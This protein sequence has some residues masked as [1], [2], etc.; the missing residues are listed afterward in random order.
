MMGKHEA[1]YYRCP[2]CGFVAVADPVWL[3][4]AYK[5]PIAQIDIGS[6]WRACRYSAVVKSL[7]NFG[8][9]RRGGRFLDYGAGFGLFVRRMR[10]LG[11][12]FRGYDAHTDNI[13][14]VG[15]EGNVNGGERFELLTALEVFEH[16]QDPL[17]LIEQMAQISSTIIF[18]TELIAEPAPAVGE[19]WYYAPVTGQH[20]SFY[21][22]RSLQ[23]IAR[24]LGLN[25]YTCGKE[26][27]MLSSKVIPQALFALL[28]T[29]ALAKWLDLF[30]PRPTLLFQDFNQGMTNSRQP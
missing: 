6:L 25:F 8:G 30:W 22:R 20:I 12:D 26:I 11:Y 14:A 23:G 3:S 9:F 7:I 5:N 29:P 18:S 17:S 1:R 21:S 24:R 19:W 13:F 28:S 15:F 10:D 2:D 4:E 27:H 16:L